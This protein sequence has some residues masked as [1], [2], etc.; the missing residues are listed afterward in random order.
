MDAKTGIKI[1]PD[2]AVA[3]EFLTA[4]FRH[5]TY[6]I[7]LCS[8]PNIKG[9]PN[10]GPEDHI[11]TRDGGDIARFIT[12]Y[13]VPL[14][15]QFF[16]VGTVEGSKRNKTNITLSLALQHGVAIETIRHAVL[17]DARGEPL[18]LIGAVDDELAEE[19][20]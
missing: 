17:R 9:D 13:N 3:V 20:P 15:G 8:L 12:D 2:I 6:K 19:Q 14:R 7:Y 18:S 16:C 5:T 1:P 11:R 10:T 4:L